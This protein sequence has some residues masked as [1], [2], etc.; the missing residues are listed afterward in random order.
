MR[1][2]NSADTGHGERRLTLREQGRVDLLDGSPIGEIAQP[3][4]RIHDIVESHLVVAELFFDGGDAHL[5]LRADIVL[6][7]ASVR[8]GG[9]SYR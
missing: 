2:A 5:G 3:D 4:Q 6:I 9:P 1:Q 7:E 8:G